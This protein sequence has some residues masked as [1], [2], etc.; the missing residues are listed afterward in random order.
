M[1]SFK[2]PDPTLSPPLFPARS[3]SDYFVFSTL[4]ERRKINVE[5]EN[6]RR[7][8]QRQEDRRDSGICDKIVS[9]K[10]LATG[11]WD[12]DRSFALGSAQR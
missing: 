9:K 7:N 5:I 1:S 10:S 6:F 11:P 8:Y 4:Q 12:D 3:S 2:I